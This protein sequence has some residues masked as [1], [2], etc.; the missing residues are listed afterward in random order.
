MPSI[1]TLTFHEGPF[2]KMKLDNVPCERITELEIILTTKIKDK[3]VSP[4]LTIAD[5]C[6]I[7]P[8]RCPLGEENT[9]PITI[10]G[11][12]VKKQILSNIAPF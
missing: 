8:L 6:N 11:N 10:Y 5:L 2:K 4:L 1:P 9:F 7:W 12:K 3:G